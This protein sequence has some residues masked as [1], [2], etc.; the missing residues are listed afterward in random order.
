[1]VPPLSKNMRMRMTWHPE[2]S[3]GQTL[4]ICELE[5]L[6][7]V[8]ETEFVNIIVKNSFLEFNLEIRLKRK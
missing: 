4:F 1:M 7:N 6:L 8:V 2:Q 3:G 5:C